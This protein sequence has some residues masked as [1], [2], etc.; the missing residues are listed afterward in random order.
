MANGMTL[1]SAIARGARKTYVGPTNTDALLG[2]GL[3][4]GWRPLIREP[5][6]GAWQ[7]NCEIS[8]EGVL[9]NYAVYACVALISNDVAKMRIKFMQLNPSTGIWKE[10]A[11][12]AFSP[13]LRKPN[14]YQTRIDFI[15]QWEQSKLTWGNAYIFLERDNRNVVVA[16]YI[17][18]PGR[19]MPAVAP[20]GSVFYQLGADNLSGLEFSIVV[21][22]SEIIHERIN[23]LFHPLVGVSPIFAC[24][25][26]AEQGLQIQRNAEKFF[27]SGAN[28][29]GVLTVPGKIDQPTADKMKTD[30]K[31]KFSGQ[32]AGSVAILPDGLKYQAMT[33][34]SVD[35]QMVEQLK[36]TA[37]QICTAYGVP[38]YKIGVSAQPAHEDIESLNQQ[39]LNDCLQTHIEQ[40]ELLLDE[41]LTIPA[42]QT[43]ELDTKQ[44]LR[45]DS[46]TRIKTNSEAVRAGIMKINEARA[47]EGL[48]PVPGGDDVYL[49]QQNFSLA[50]LQKRD[51][52]DNPFVVDNPLRNPTPS[53]DGSV[54]QADP[55]E[56]D[57]PKKATA[58]LLKKIMG[59]LYAMPEHVD[60]D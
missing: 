10:S 52:L 15:K 5:F 32:N 21:P 54:Q 6:A 42:G 23:P 34:S 19:V 49:Q 31:E 38:G 1:F 8:V 45:M 60:A 14:R 13:V 50:A 36:L 18:N 7:Q 4:G 25:L 57:T 24:G 22:A 41:G 58:S 37:E 29:S 3:S 27:R 51:A 20:D 26:A 16:M 40:L 17:L 56:E 53:I 2:S 12:N 30:W 11:S 9:S 48:D 28:P 33:M 39:Y 47:E 44:L 43:V 59:H 46:A 55:P 35:S